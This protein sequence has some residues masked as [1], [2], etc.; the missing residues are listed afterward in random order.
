LTAEEFFFFAGESTVETVAGNWRRSLS[1]LFKL[2]NVTGGH[3]HRFWDTFS[4]EL[5]NEG[6]RLERVSMLPGHAGI[7]IA[8][9]RY[10]PWVRSREA[11]LEAALR[12]ALARDPLAFA[13]TKGA[14]T[15]HGDSIISN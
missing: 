4:V 6:V 13:Q 11:L 12:R 9:R 7:R 10:A 14:L 3:P 1:K 2:A 8:E 5:L 15:V